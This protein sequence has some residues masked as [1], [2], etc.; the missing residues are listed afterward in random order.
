LARLGTLAGDVVLV[1]LD[2]QQ[3]VGV[4]LVPAFIVTLLL[5]PLSW[6]RIRLSR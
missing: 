3:E 6:L 4:P 1:L 5:T 2:F